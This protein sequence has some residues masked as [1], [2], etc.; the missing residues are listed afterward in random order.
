MR[1]YSSRVGD[2]VHLPT[3]PATVLRTPPTLKRIQ[4]GISGGT[5]ESERETALYDLEIVRHV[6]VGIGSGM[7]LCGRLRGLRDCAEM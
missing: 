7:H 6:K 5:R 2:A 4:L 3:C 1:I